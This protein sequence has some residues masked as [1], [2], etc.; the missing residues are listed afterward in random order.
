[1]SWQLTN[2]VE[3]F[4]AA[5]GDFLRAERARNTIALTVTQSLRADPSLYSSPLLGWCTGAAGVSAAFLHTP[6]FPA[7]LT[8]M[9][10]A[11]A[12]AL[13]DELVPARPDLP[14]IAAPED[15]AWSFA[16]AWRE[17]AGRDATVR[18]RERLFRLGQLSWPDP[19]PDGAARLADGGDRDLLQDW[20]SWF[21]TETELASARDFSQTIASRLSYGGFTLWQAGGIPVSLAGQSRAVDGMVRIGPVYTPPEHR[22]RGYSGAVTAAVSQSAVAAGIGEVLLYTDLANPVSN[23]LY[24]RLGYQPVEDRIVLTFG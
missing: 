23:A 5:A 19:R 24:R 10:G 14:G 7:F 8:A 3:D 13:A 21:G 22:G 17:R 18:R 2:A 16:G 12:S 6:P 9:D 1:M 20:L 4:L 15:T 11:V